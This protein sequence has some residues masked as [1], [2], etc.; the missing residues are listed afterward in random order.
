M[1]REIVEIDIETL[2]AK[3]EELLELIRAISRYLDI[4][5][6]IIAI[7]NEKGVKV[8]CG[9][10]IYNFFES[11]ATQIIRTLETI[12]DEAMEDIDILWIGH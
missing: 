3:K 8:S 9:S 5:S 11:E 12:K 4:N 6:L 10:E 7:K 2:E 1:S